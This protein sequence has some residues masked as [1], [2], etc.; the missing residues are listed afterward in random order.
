[1]I[2]APYF[3]KYDHLPTVKAFVNG[4]TAAAVGA[5]SGSV[6]VI[7][8]RSIVDLPTAAVMLVTVLLLWRLKKLQEPV[9]VLAAAAFGL[10][11]FPLVHLR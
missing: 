4:I 3:K 7:S 10:V 9:I 2:P 1:M 11:V 6:L 8:K 5:I